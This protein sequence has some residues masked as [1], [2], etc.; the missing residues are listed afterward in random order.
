MGSPLSP[1]LSNLYMELIEHY[2]ILPHHLLNNSIWLRYVDDVFAAIP[3]SNSSTNIL[4]FINSIHPNIKFTMETPSPTNNS[5]PFLDTLF[6]WDHS[7]K[8]SYTIYRKPTS[9]SNYIHWFSTHT[10][11]TK[12]ATLSALYLRALKICSPAFLNTETNYLKN[13]FIKLKYPI[14]IINKSYKNA[15]T[16]FYS[17]ITHENKKTNF[18]PIPHINIQHIK[19]IIPKNI[20]FVPSNNIILKKVFKPPK[21]PNPIPPCIYRI[22]CSVCNLNYIGE[23]I[24]YKRRIHQHQHDLNIDNQNSALVQ[25]RQ[26]NDHFINPNNSSIIKNINNYSKRKI[27]ESFCIYNLPNYNQSTGDYKIDQLQN[28]IMCQ[29]TFY[30]SLIKKQPTSNQTP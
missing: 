20:T 15:K 24:D 21:S 5:L 30:K 22:P 23:S 27:A 8:P 9:S 17:I 2:F 7:T 25:H 19:P 26:N 29:S 14:H 12:I 3:I 13:T 1:M 28:A 4:N 6:I 18:I 11:N 16:K 10:T